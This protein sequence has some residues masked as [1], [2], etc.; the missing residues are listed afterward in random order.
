VHLK[1][2]VPGRDFALGKVLDLRDAAE[3]DSC[4]RC[5]TAMIVKQ[6]IEVGHVF[7]LGTKYSKAMGATFLDDKGR[8]S[9]SS[10]AVTAL[11]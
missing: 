7:K 6:G 10:W 5:G 1:G 9:R 4:P 3:G 8:R 11:A 2:V